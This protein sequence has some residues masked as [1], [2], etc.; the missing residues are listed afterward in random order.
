[1]KAGLILVLFGVAA[2]LFLAGCGERDVP[3]EVLAAADRP[4]QESWE[5]NL[6]IEVDGFRRAR[7]EAPYVA[8][9]VRGDTTYARFGPGETVRRIR[10]YVFDEDGQPS[11]TVESDHLEHLEDR[12]IFIAIGDVVV[13][14]E[15][16]RRLEGE[17]LTWH[18][19]AGEIRSDGFVRITTPTERIQGYQLV[20][21][22]SLDTYRLARITGQVEV[23]DA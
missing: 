14:S 22:E 19:A 15:S 6:A 1:M 9:F 21:D 23:E 4:D 16:G 11:A 8:R 20:A 3:P 13:E 17:R 12:R 10:V 5:V 2:T 18:E 7:L